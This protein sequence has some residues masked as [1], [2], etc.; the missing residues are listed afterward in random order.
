MMTHLVGHTKACLGGG[1]LEGGG[2][3][4]KR[5]ETLRRRRTRNACLAALVRLF[6]SQSRRS[7]SIFETGSSLSISEAEEGGRV[8]QERSEE[9]RGEKMEEKRENIAIAM[10][11]FSFSPRSVGGARWQV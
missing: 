8:A 1:T 9:R 5:R 11:L 10:L 3:E 2:G 6:V 7:L 4:E